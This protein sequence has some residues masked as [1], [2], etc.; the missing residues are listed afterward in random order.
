[1]HPTAPH[2]DVWAVGLETLSRA[3]HD[4]Y[5]TDA[6]ITESITTMWRLWQPAHLL[7]WTSAGTA[8]IVLPHY[9]RL[10]WLNHVALVSRLTPTEIRR[11]WWLLSPIHNPRVVAGSGTTIASSA[12]TG[13]EWFERASIVTQRSPFVFDVALPSPHPRRHDRAE[14]AFRARVDFLIRLLLFTAPTWVQ[15]EAFPV[16]QPRLSVTPEALA[17]WQWQP[18]GVSSF[19]GTE[20]DN[21]TARLRL[22]QPATR[23][24]RRSTAVPHRQAR[25]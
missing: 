10:A 13:F 7:E 9:G 5:P 15:H 3:L 8:V 24:H 14:R 21:T 22:F 18:T 6:A 12:F 23:H 11:F 1:M 16:P 25:S 20:P 2:V 4:Q 17:G 19:L